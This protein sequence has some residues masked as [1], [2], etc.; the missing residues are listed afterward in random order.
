[1]EYKKIENT[2]F[3]IV[4]NNSDKYVILFGKNQVDEREF[5]DIEEAENE[6]KNIGFTETQWKLVITTSAIM[7]MELINMKENEEI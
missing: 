3:G 1:M 6:I 5:I 7:A 2:P 4:K